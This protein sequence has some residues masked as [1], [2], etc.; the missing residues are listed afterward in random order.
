MIRPL[1][2]AFVDSAFSTDLLS[3]FTAVASDSVT[4]NGSQASHLQVSSLDSTVFFYV[5]VRALPA[6]R[7]I[8]Q[9]LEDF[10]DHTPPY[11]TGHQP[12][13]YQ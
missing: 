2:D 4:L 9:A 5:D 7:S 10:R 1:Q 12:R 11:R 6:C 8:G 13:S 3:M